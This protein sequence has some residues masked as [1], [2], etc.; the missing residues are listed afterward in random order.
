LI[1]PITFGIGVEPL[2]PMMSRTFALIAFAGLL[3]RSHL[4]VM[5][6]P[7]T[8]PNAAQVKSQEPEGTCS[9]AA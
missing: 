2:C 6:V 8:F 5:N 3:L 4:E 9:S 7:L 1:C